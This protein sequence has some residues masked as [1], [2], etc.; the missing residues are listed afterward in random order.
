MDIAAGNGIRNVMLIGH[1][2]KLVKVG[3]G[4]MNTH[5]RYADARMETLASCILRAGGDADTAREVLSCN[6]TE[7]ALVFI[8]DKV[9]YD[10]TMEILAERVEKA[11]SQ[12]VYGRMR[13]GAILFSMQSGLC[14]IG[15]K[16]EEMFE[17]GTF[18]RGGLGS[19]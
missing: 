16:A 7:D 13:I 6:T 14:L 18:C 2:G 17:D 15:E 8:R 12:H 5:S 19:T 11:L 10:K 3:S 1:I 9:C 4:I